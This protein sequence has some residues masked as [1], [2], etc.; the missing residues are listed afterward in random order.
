M[1]PPSSNSF[2]LLKTKTTFV[3]LQYLL[4]NFSPNIIEIECTASVFRA[5]MSLMCPPF[6]CITHS[7]GDAV[8]YHLLTPRTSESF[9]DP[10]LNAHQISFNSWPYGRPPLSSFDRSNSI[11]IRPCKLCRPTVYASRPSRQKKTP[12]IFQSPLNAIRRSGQPYSKHSTTRKMRLLL[13]IVD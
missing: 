10:R 8:I 2:S 7:T 4:H 5:N 6:C 1:A 11:R 3:G 13:I 9:L 12:L